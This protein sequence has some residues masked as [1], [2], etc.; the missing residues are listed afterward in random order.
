MREASTDGKRLLK[1]LRR[2]PVDRTP[3]WLMRQAGRYLPEYRAVRAEAGSFLD[4][5]YTPDFAEEVTL[6]PIR[7]YGFD[8]AILF[9]DILVVPDA[10]GQPVAFKE[11][12]G[13]VLE[14]I[15]NAAELATLKPVSALRD[16]LAPVYE[17]VRRLKNSLPAETALIGFA[18]APWTVATYMVGGRGSPDQAMAKA[19]AY[20]APDEFQKLIDLLVAATVE[21]LSA[22]VEAG[23]EVLQL[24]DTWAGSLPE[25]S[26]ERFALKPMIEIRAALKVRFPDLP[27]I[28]FPRGAGPMTVEY[29]RATG[30]DA[31]SLD[32]GMSP[33]WARDNLQGAGCL[34]G[35]LDPLLLVA[36]GAEMQ[37]QVLHILDTLGH[38]PFIF[39]L[40]HGIVPQTPPDHVAALVEI[41]RE[42]RP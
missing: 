16:K 40:G 5:C 2:E 31:L 7:R 20:R 22:Q 37:Q 41:V 23:A 27:V 14:P 33:V 6:Q 9:S 32:T 21:H 24:F 42:W 30:L 36:G 17:T 12:E 18:G 34:Q 26:F 1:V 10:L 19:W 11:G 25:L 29:F 28:G 39:N 35:N 8:A 3:L 15:R 13:P 4:L 38:G